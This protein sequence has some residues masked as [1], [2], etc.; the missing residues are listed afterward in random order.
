MF[1]ENVLITPIKYIRKKANDSEVNEK[2]CTVNKSH[3]KAWKE[4]K[5]NKKML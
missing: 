1:K 4:K 3:S 5:I 2:D